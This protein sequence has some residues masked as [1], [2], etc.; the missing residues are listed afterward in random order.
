MHWCMGVGCDDSTGRGLLVVVFH[1]FFFSSRRRHTR[2]K[3]DWSSDVCSSDLARSRL[4]WVRLVTQTRYPA[5]RPSRI[6]A[7]ATPPPAP[8]TK[9]VAPGWAPD[10]ANSIL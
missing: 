2:F 7:V 1:V 8:W 4:A 9:M 5:A 6:S 3:C 10:L